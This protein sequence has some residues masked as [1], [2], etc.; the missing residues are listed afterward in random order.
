MG[1][2]R[3]NKKK[4]WFNNVYDQ[5]HGFGNRWIDAK[6][7]VFFGNGEEIPEKSMV[8]CDEVGAKKKCQ[9]SLGKQD[10]TTASSSPSLNL[11]LTKVEFLSKVLL[12]SGNTHLTGPYYKTRPYSVRLRFLI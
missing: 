10:G 6:K 9:S 8:V 7:T 5:Y 12:S 11:N 1:I 3:Y 4:T 2:D